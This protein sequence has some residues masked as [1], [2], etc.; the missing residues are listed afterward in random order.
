MNKI[1]S[2]KNKNNKSDIAG[3]IRHLGVIIENVDDKVSLLAEQYGDIKKT[4]DSH[5]EILN[6]HTEMIVKNTEDIEIIKSD[7]SFIKNSLKV[8]VDLEEFKYLE[9]RVSLLE[10]KLASASGKSASDNIR[11]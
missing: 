11:K 4:L 6:S 10:K 1:K 5:T 7:T 9:Q 8:K 3:E 2:N